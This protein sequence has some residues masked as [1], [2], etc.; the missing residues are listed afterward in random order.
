MTKF[1]LLGAAAVILSSALAGPVMAQQ[2]ISNPDA[3]RQMYPNAN[4]RNKGPGNPYTGSYQRWRDDR[5]ANARY[6]D[7]WNNGWDRN[8]N[9]G[10]W[11][12]RAFSSEVETGSRQ[13]NAS[14]QQSG[15]PFQFNRNGKGSDVAAGVVGGAIGPQRHRTAPF[16]GDAYAYYNDNSGGYSN[17]GYRGG[18]HQSYARERSYARLNGFVCQPGTWFKGEDGRR[19]LC[20]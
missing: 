10:F 17:S 9:S 12:A 6:D 18:P 5:N 11:P 2:A 3:C 7:N 1:G 16:R 14:N 13:E 8:D 4:C 15:A 20:Q 19:H